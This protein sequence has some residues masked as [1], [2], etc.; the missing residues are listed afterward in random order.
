V[1]EKIVSE[2]LPGFSP[3]AKGQEHDGLETTDRM[4]D[5]KEV[6]PDFSRLNAGAL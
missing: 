6:V 5:R 2:S 4:S 1:N 3:I